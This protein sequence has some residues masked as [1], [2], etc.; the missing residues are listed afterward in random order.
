METMCLFRSVL[1]GDSDAFMQSKPSQ[2][3]QCYRATFTEAVTVGTVS[4]PKGIEIAAISTCEHDL[5]GVEVFVGNQGKMRSLRYVPLQ[6][7]V[8]IK[9]GNLDRD[10]QQGRMLIEGEGRDW[11]KACSQGTSRLC[12][13]NLK[14]GER[15]GRFSLRALSRNPI[16]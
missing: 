2:T 1:L 11:Y 14:V 8:L 16:C 9:S 7:G 12:V 13:N 6:D 4:P 15:Q 10:T 5:F 3:L